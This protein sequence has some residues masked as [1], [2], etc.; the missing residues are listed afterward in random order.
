[1]SSTR[2]YVDTMA[3]FIAHDTAR[4][5]PATLPAP[6]KPAKKANKKKNSTKAVLTRKGKYSGSKLKRGTRE[7]MKKKGFKLS[8][9]N[10]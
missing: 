10:K 1:M 7:T 9:E 2:R 8:K 3:M 5:M 4:R 6:E